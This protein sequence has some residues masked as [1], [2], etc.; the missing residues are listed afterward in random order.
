M[1]LDDFKA[2]WQ[3]LDRRLAEQNALNIHLFKEAKLTQV[4]SQLRPLVIGQVVQLIAGILMSLLFG[5]FWVDHLDTPHLM[6]C[7]LALHAYGILFIVLA[8]R[9]LYAINQIDYAA[10]VVEI[11]KQLANLRTWRIRMAPLFAITGS[12]I[13]IPLL[14]VIFA[15]LGA[16]VW[17]NDPNVVYWFIASSVISLAIVFGIIQWLRH[18]SRQ[19]LASSLD[20]GSV[21]G[22]IRRAQ[23]TLAEL[24]RFARE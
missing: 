21:G 22:S 6:L 20:E 24:E 15:W 13:W 17:T 14:L 19:H 1:E 16:D 12:V 11:Q 23:G 3:T 9:E 10:P 5:S 8:G 4:K 2:A 7:G 18:P